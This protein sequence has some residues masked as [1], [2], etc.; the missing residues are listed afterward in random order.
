MSDQATPPSSPEGHPDPAKWYQ[1]RRETMF[2]TQR[3]ILVYTI[4]IT[5]VLYFKPDAVQKGTELLMWF[6][7]VM[8]IPTVGYYSNTA[9]DNLMSK[10]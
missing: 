9:I 3:Y 10:R 6:Y 7:I 4:A 8:A 2:R 1:V 5:I